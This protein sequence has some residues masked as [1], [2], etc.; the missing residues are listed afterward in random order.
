MSMH[1]GPLE[2]IDHVHLTGLNRQKGMIKGKGGDGGGLEVGHVVLVC[3]F[4]Y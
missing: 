4:V 1:V 3:H 2:R